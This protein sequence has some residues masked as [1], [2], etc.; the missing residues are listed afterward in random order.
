MAC[1]PKCRP[2][3]RCVGSTCTQTAEADSSEDGAP[4]ESDAAEPA[5]RRGDHETDDSDRDHR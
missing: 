3:E 5:E 1:K 4:A 2:E